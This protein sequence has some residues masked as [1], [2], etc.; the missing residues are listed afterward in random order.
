MGACKLL[1]QWA[2]PIPLHHPDLWL[3]GMAQIRAVLGLA[4]HG[5]QGLL[6]DGGPQGEGGYGEGP[7]RAS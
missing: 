6:V 5:G 1:V 3:R 7:R 4:D 2:H